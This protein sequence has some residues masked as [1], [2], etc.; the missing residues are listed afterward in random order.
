MEAERQKRT[1]RRVKWLC[2]TREMEGARNTKT[3]EQTDRLADRQKASVDREL[4]QG[5]NSP[6]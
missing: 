3:D 4:D 5:A 1:N 6:S 2:F